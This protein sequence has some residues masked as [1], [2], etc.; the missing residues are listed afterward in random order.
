MHIYKTCKLQNNKN[1]E[2]SKV[3][4]CLIFLSIYMITEN[5]VYIISVT[6]NENGKDKC[7]I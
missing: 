5:H 2:N 4:N 1:K 6:F 3:E 7:N